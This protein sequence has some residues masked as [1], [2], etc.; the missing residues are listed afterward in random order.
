MT[1]IEMLIAVAIFSLLSVMGVRALESVTRTS[2]HL[3]LRH[4]QLHDLTILLRLLEKDFLENDQQRVQIGSHA[5]TATDELRLIGAGVTYALREDGQITRLP[6]ASHGGDAAPIT[7]S[8]RVKRID[9]RM[10]Q[11]GV[12]H[13]L[14]QLESRFAVQA[15]RLELHLAAKGS[16][17]KTILLSGTGL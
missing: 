11:A 17:V 7:F 6:N 14:E 12:W 5:A 8:T 4:E 16:I 9:I 3:E 13:Q 15:I 2:S 10:A 1:L